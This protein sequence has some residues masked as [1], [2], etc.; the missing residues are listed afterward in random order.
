MVEIYFS[1]HM[2]NKIRLFFLILL[3]VAVYSCT[4]KLQDIKFVEPLSYQGLVC[5]T[6]I[7]TLICT[8]DAFLF[9]NI[10]E[11]YRIP[12]DFFHVKAYGCSLNEFNSSDFF[13][14]LSKT[15]EKYSDFDKESIL[16]GEVLDVFFNENFEKNDFRLSN[17]LKKDHYKFYMV[18]VTKFGEN[19]DSYMVLR[20]SIHNKSYIS[21]TLFLMNIKDKNLKS[22]SLL[23]QYVQDKELTIYRET[24]TN[25]KLFYSTLRFEFTPDDLKKN[26]SLNFYTDRVFYEIFQFD[27]EGY[28]ELVN[29]QR[30]V[31]GLTD[32]LY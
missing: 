19:Y 22:I 3:F 30:K 7:D 29:E 23:S 27:E 28:V 5:S 8:S 13:F 4:N 15:R 32:N 20:E 12:D 10:K 16:K 1:D 11:E 18:G 26:A 2:F 31:L 9:N 21:N 24:R 25:R 6:P 17:P 14:R